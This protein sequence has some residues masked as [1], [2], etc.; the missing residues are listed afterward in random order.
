MSDLTERQTRFIEAYMISGNATQAAI[1]AGYAAESADGEGSRLLV[2]VRIAEE[3]EKRRKARALR[4]EIDADWVLLRFKDISNRCMQ[5]EPVLIF[6]GEKWVESGEYKFDSNGANKATENIAKHIGFYAK[7]K[8]KPQETK[9]ARK[10][11]TVNIGVK[12]SPPKPPD[13]G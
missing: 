10:R 3:L 9:K 12:Y 7:D 2:N 4:A 8:E 11:Y 6:D 5:A 1:E 13:A